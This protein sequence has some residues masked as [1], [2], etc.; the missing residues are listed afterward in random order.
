MWV[1]ISAATLNAKSP[2]K[3]FGHPWAL[4]ENVTEATI[5][6]RQVWLEV[7]VLQEARWQE[8]TSLSLRSYYC[9]R[10]TSRVSICQRCDRGNIYCAGPCSDLARRESQRE[11]ERRYRNS[12]I[13]R[14][15]S[16]QRQQRYRDRQRDCVTHQGSPMQ[17]DAARKEL[18]STAKEQSPHESGV[19]AL[20]H[21]PAPLFAAQDTALE[22][23][24]TFCN[25][26]SS[27][28]LRMDFLSSIRSRRLSDRL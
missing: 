9:R 5:F 2:G 22:F 3:R 4:G 28:F 8:A 15:N 10:C 17:G 26:Y 14:R 24:C 13:G 18:C 11:S 20:P 19:N 25:L 23:R 1:Q 6:R 27:P 7:P 12:P 21:E 16:A